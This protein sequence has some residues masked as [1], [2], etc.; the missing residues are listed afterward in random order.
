MKHLI[1]AFTLLFLV[2]PCKAETIIVDPNGSADF[3]SIQDAI[4]YSW[5]G[6]VIIVEPG[7]YNENIYFNARAVRVS[8]TD[9]DDPNIVEATIITGNPGYDY[10]VIFDFAEENNSVITG[11]TITGPSGGIHCYGSAPTISKNV[12]RNCN[13]YGIYGQHCASPNIANNKIID[14]NTNR[15][16]YGCHRSILNN[17]IARNRGGLEDCNGT[18]SGNIIADNIGSGGLLNCNGTIKYNT[19][20]S[21][22]VSASV[23]AYGGGLHRCNGTISHNTISGNAVFTGRDYNS[24]GGGL[25][26]CN[27]TISNNTISGNISGRSDYDGKSYGGGLAQC[28]GTIMNNMITGNTATCHFSYHSCGGGLY[29]CRYLIKNNTIGGNRAG[30]CG[31]G[32]NHCENVVNNTIVGN[33]SYYGGAIS[34]CNTIIRNN[35]IAFNKA[36]HTGGIRGSC[37][38]SYNA[39]WMNE[40]GNFANGALPGVGDISMNPYFAINGYRDVNDLWV[41][42]DYH[43]KSAAGRW[44]PNTNEWVTDVNTSDCIDAGDPASDW[45]AELWPHGTLINMGAYG[46]IPEASM[47]LSDAGNIADLDNDGMVN[48]VD[49][50]IFSDKWQTKGTL[51][52]Q[53]LNHDELVSAEDLLTFCNNWLWE[54]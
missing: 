10:T 35:I 40:N 41:D 37:N 50:S 16:I 46:G 13:R 47:S 5:D 3:N 33:S 14:N 44:D 29:E 23:H 52:A 18:I 4:N 48:M 34:D 36:A 9:P 49:Y 27:G 31:E 45:T 24:Y 8:S 22:T 54:E 32:L 19:I 21:N 30:G 2:I 6:D 38:N 28:N 25:A 39:F 43:L 26:Q 17:T 53:D 15:G 42:G 12:I 1:L 20:I 51:F 11:F 7:T